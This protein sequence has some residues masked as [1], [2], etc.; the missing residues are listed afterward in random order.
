LSTADG[1][2]GNKS[3]LQQ[4]DLAGGDAADAAIGSDP[5]KRMNR[6]VK[7]RKMITSSR[8]TL[9]VAAKVMLLFAGACVY[10]AVSFSLE[11]KEFNKQ[12]ISMGEQAYIARR[13]TLLGDSGVSIPEFQLAA[14]RRNVFRAPDFGFTGG[15][16]CL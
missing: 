14:F 7:N 10:F 1:G 3:S 13:N 15:M 16:R 12:F 4:S 5:N 9:L 6:V 8:R 2:T 11:F